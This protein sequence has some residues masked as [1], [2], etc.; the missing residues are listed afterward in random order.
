MKNNWFSREPG[1]SK[2]T[3]TCNPPMLHAWEDEEFNFV[4]DFRVLGVH[5]LAGGT[6]HWASVK[7][8][9]P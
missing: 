1:R 2:L 7:G 8:L 9:G 4:L 5:L 3:Q 6:M